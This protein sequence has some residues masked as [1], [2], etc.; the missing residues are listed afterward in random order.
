M[1]ASAFRH[2]DVV[3]ATSCFKWS[4]NTGKKGDLSY[5]GCCCRAGLST[6][7]TAHRLGSST[8]KSQK[9]YIERSKKEK[10]SSCVDKNVM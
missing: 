5:V 1:A 7:E 8:Q 6:L 3:K 4:S 10:I 2:V 9:V